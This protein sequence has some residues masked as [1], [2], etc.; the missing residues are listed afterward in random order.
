MADLELVLDVH[1]ELGEG[2]VWDAERAVLL[3]V[4]IMRG[5]V[6][7]FNPSTASD[8][9]VNIGLPV[10]AV[11]PTVRGDWIAA[12]GQ[13]FHRVE[14]DSGRRTQVADATPGRT[15]LRMNDGYVDPLGNFWAGTMSLVR[16]P[17]QGALFRLTPDG[18]VKLVLAPV[19]TSNGLDWSPDGRL[20][21]YVDTG[22]RRID[23]FDVDLRAGTLGRRRPF[24]DLTREAGRPDGLVVDA[25]G[26]VWVALWRGGA[27]RRYLPNGMLDLELAVPAALVTKC[28]F[29]GPDMADLYVTTAS[30]DLTA[31]ERLAQPHAGGVFRSRPGVVGQVPRVFNG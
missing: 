2:P 15:D 3:F 30:R 28:A 31:E 8:R 5:D 16:T 6:H 7:A 24:V 29:G 23:T 26:G 22:T 14:P 20:L 9:V 19:T 11:A 18:N 10:G 21:Y 13:G 4:D 25:E 27:V 1:A 12:A 17:D